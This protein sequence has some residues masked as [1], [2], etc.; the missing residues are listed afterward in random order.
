VA[1]DNMDL[2]GWLRKQLA[3]AEPDMLREM[4]RSFAEALMGAEADALCEAAFRE[5]S[6]DTRLRRPVEGVTGCS[7]Q[8]AIVLPCPGFCEDSVLGGSQP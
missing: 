4:V 6:G 7:R 3:E 5:R 1:E 8:Y 2:L